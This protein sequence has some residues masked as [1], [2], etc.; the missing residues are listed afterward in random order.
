MSSIEYMSLALLSKREK[1]LDHIKEGEVKKRE[2]LQEGEGEVT[3]RRSYIGRY[4]TEGEGTVARSKERKKENSEDN[5]EGV[6]VLIKG[7]YKF[8]FWHCL[9]ILT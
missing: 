3:R 9:T 8:S 5:S 2:K 6:V 7:E 1:L 4:I